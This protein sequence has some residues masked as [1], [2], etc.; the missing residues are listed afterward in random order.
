[1]RATAW[2]GV[3]CLCAPWTAGMSAAQAQD[4]VWRCGSTLTNRLPDDEAQRGA[5]VPVSLPRVTTL[6]APRFASVAP[7]PGASFTMPAERVQVDPTDQKR[8]DEQARELLKAERDKALER[9]QQAQRLGD[10]S[11]LEQARADVSSLDRELARR[12]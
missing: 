3:A 4:L 2:I 5:C 11:M 10:Q 8:R 9:V 1:M 7:P 6:P 12:P